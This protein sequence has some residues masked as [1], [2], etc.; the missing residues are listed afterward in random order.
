MAV[1]GESD[2]F[3]AVQPVAIDANRF[4]PPQHLFLKLISSKSSQKQSHI[5]L[6]NF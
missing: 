4:Y 2:M 3:G 6:D 5:A 1:S